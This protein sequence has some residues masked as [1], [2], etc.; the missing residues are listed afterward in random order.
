MSLFSFKAR[1]RQGNA[2]KG[3]V[4]APSRQVAEGELKDRDLILLSLV[5]EKRKTI[6]QSASRILNR[7]TS[8][9]VVI[10][11]RQLSTMITANVPLVRALKILVQQTEKVPFKILINDVAEEVDGGAKLSQVMARYPQVFDDFFVYMIRSGETTGKLD[12]VLNYLADQKEK[13]YDLMSKIRGAMIYPAFIMTGLVVVG[14]IMMIFVVPKLTE[15]LRESGTDLPLSTKILIATSD[16]MQHQWWVIIIVM[17]GL[18]AIYRFG[19]RVKSGKEIVD[20]VKLKLPIF[21]QLF[22]KIYLGRFARS[23]STL[24]AS[25]VPVT[26]SLEIVAD[27][28][29]NDVYRNLTLQT[30]EEVEAGNSIISVFATDKNVPPMFNQMMKVGEETGRLDQI[31]SKLAD[32]YAR[33]VEALI[34]NLV[35]LIEPIIMIILGL[36]VGVLIT[37]IL[38]PMYNLASA[39]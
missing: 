21:G 20:K 23:L 37:A 38:L 19:S 7:I 31:L 16:F 22:K 2:I 5:E 24:I 11:S 25:G 13:D 8:R 28:V 18:V 1:D 36:G 3:T 35:T 30:I 14:F 29:G 34:F 12:D 32:F 33:E 39:M 15:I 9:D 26:H 4:E 17:V 6:F 27:I 10:F